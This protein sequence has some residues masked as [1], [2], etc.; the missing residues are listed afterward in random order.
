MKALICAVTLLFLTDLCL[1]QHVYPIRADS[2]RIYS[3]CDTAEL[4]LENRTKDTLGFLFN[5]G[6]GRT[7]F[8]KLKLI[9]VGA[10]GIAI[11]GQDTIQIAGGS[12][13]AGT[14][15]TV[16]DKGSVTT[17][18]ITTDSGF[19]VKNDAIYYGIEGVPQN[20]LSFYDSNY[21]L[22]KAGIGTGLSGQL[23]S[24][25]DIS[26]PYQLGVPAVRVW[27]GCTVIQNDLTI[28]KG[29]N[30]F[31][32]GP[33]LRGYAIGDD[34][35]MYSTALYLG[36]DEP[37]YIS[38]SPDDD[39]FLTNVGIGYFYNALPEARLHIKGDLRLDDSKGILIRALGDIDE[40]TNPSDLRLKANLNS[41]V[42]T[43]SGRHPGTF[44]N[45]ILQSTAATSVTNGVGNVGI[46]NETPTSTLDVTGSFSLNSIV[47]T[48]TSMTLDINNYVVLVNNT[49]A[50]NI[51]LPLANTCKG[52]MYVIKKI[53]NNTIAA[54]VVRSGTDTIDGSASPYTAIASNM[55][56]QTFI[57]NGIA[58]YAIGH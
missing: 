37:V 35:I 12:G 39:S 8:R 20:L 43:S 51:T 19:I 25:L 52:R 49:T 55:V 38:N 13:S 34:E 11:E 5:K 42:I 7:E 10:S 44:S 33:R 1:A 58:W 28:D 54:S 57:S 26:S 17:H 4:I 16:T 53:S 36:K 23:E 41:S 6:K 22:L 27:D 50:V 9:N 48:T 2:V 21:P 29:T 15:Q 18:S 3:N 30:G 31:R 32:T 40:I 56:T 24:Y 46:K 47:T 14:L 45:L